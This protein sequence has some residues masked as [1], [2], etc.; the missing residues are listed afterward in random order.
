MTTDNYKENKQELLT[1]A[2]AINQ[3]SNLFNNIDT[4]SRSNSYLP[5]A[6]FVKMAQELYGPGTRILIPA[7][8][9]YI[10]VMLSMLGLDIEKKNELTKRMN[11]ELTR[12]LNE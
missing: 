5:V 9:T 6:E 12:S 11:D 4:E 1:A 10:G 3:A 2:L 8:I 7:A